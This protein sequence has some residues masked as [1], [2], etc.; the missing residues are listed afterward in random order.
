MCATPWQPTKCSFQRYIVQ[1]F[2]CLENGRIE[3]RLKLL[4]MTNRKLHM[5]FRL[6]SKIDDLELCKF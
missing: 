5:R 2:L 4:F 6:T 1:V 3:I